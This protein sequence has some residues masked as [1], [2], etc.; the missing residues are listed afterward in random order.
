[1]ND[2]DPFPEK[3]ELLR[4]VEGLKDWQ[5]RLVLSFVNN[6]FGPEQTPAKEQN[7]PTALE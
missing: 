1:M 7:Q 5:T 6:L 3:T 2:L 4:R